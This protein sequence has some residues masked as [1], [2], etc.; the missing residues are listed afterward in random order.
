MFKFLWGSL[1]AIGVVLGIVSSLMA[2]LDVPGTERLV[3]AT[4]SL[5]V[6]L[7]LFR[8]LTTSF[9][10]LHLQNNVT[11]RLKNKGIN[12]SSESIFSYLPLRRGIKHQTW[13]SLNAS[14]VTCKID[15]AN[16]L[17]GQ[18]TAQGDRT[19]DFG[20]QLRTLRRYQ[21]TRTTEYSPNSFATA[22]EFFYFRVYV[23]TARLKI[24]IEF[25]SDRLPT[26]V[27]KVLRI[28]GDLIDQGTITPNSHRVEWTVWFPTVGQEYWFQWNW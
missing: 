21:I 18:A 7:I 25:P 10:G 13:H 22:D 24:I 28:N 15:G 20:K 14:S 23:P 3:W 6:A 11:L 5:G 16:A 2:I 1:G 26:A 12:G 19:V 8:L 4:V 9:T 17:V 27:A